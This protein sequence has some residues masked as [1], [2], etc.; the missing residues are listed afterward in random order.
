MDVNKAY[1]MTKDLVKYY[2]PEIS[3]YVMLIDGIGKKY[4]KPAGRTIAYN[5]GRFDLLLDKDFVRR[6]DEIHVLYTIIHEI[7]HI[8]TVGHDHNDIWAKKFNDIWN[9]DEER[10]FPVSHR[11]PHRIFN[12]NYV[13]NRY[14]IWGQYQYKPINEYI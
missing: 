3:V 5:D 8:L 7:A 11:H 2:C 10:H 6:N 1:L 12:S 13:Y 9:L 14:A 4:K